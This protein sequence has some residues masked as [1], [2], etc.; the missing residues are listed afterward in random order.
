MAD[1]FTKPRCR[2]GDLTP[3]QD[4]PDTRFAQAPDDKPTLFDLLSESEWRDPAHLRVT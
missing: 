3:V 1:R 2:P 4:E